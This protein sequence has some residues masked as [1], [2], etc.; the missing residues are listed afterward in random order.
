MAAFYFRFTQKKNHKS[1]NLQ[2]KQ[3]KQTGYGPRV[4]LALK[5]KNVANAQL[6][7]TP[8]TACKP[9][10]VACDMSVTHRPTDI[11]G[12]LFTVRTGTL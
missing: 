10:R 9:L 4:T 1:R 2:I 12:Q 3:N 7:T 5:Q 8:S 6:P 11:Q